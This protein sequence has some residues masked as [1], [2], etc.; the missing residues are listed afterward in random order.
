M[1]SHPAGDGSMRCRKLTWRSQSRDVCFWH[2]S[3][4]LSSTASSCMRSWRLR[5]ALAGSPDQINSG[6][7]REALSKIRRPQGGGDLVRSMRALCYPS[8]NDKFSARLSV[9]SKFSGLAE[10]NERIGI[11]HYGLDD[12]AVALRLRHSALREQLPLIEARRKP[13]AVLHNFPDTLIVLAS[14][15]PCVLVGPS[16][17]MVTR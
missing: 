9:G 17:T 3:G 15:L 5:D 13:V 1:G 4:A 14:V 6:P 8:I 11:E 16:A 12:D 2:L 7:M 10:G